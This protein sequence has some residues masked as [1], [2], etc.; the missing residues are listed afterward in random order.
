MVR[1]VLV[2]G[3][4]D[5]KVAGRITFHIHFSDF[6]DHQPGFRDHQPDFRDHQPDYLVKT[7]NEKVILVGGWLARREYEPDHKINFWR[8]RGESTFDVRES[9]EP[10]FSATVFLSKIP[11]SYKSRKG[12]L[13]ERRVLSHGK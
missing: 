6:R 13:H 3:W 12:K 9:V 5:L 2:G 11:C 8:P 1:L 7:K 4:Q 10:F